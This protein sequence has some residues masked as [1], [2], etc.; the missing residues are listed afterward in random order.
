MTWIDFAFFVVAIV[1]I[2]VQSRR[3]FL[4][5]F[6]DFLAG[7]LAYTLTRGIAGNMPGMGAPIAIFLGIF[8]VLLVGSYFVYGLFSFTIEAYDPLL[9]G[10]FGFVLACVVMH[11]LYWAGD[12]ARAGGETP[13][14]ILDSRLASSFYHY[15]WWKRFLSFMGRLGQYD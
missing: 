12:G 11:V 13:L 10:L 14:W 5:S 6:L 4:Q 7:L 1:L 8:A 15:D 3:G 9:G 2:A